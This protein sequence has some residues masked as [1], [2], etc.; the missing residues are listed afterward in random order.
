MV[1]IVGVRRVQEAHVMTMMVSNSNIP[2]RPS[3]VHSG[4]QA[5]INRV[6][7]RSH[8]HL[9]KFSPAG[10]KGIWR[11]GWSSG[12]KWEGQKYRFDIKGHRSYSTMQPRSLPMATIGN[13]S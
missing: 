13:M 6:E 9:E 8:G 12:G 10:L 7:K 1:P 3:P 2:I 5:E 4:F 11:W